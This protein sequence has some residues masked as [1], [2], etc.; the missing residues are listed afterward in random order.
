MTSHLDK[1]ASAHNTASPRQAVKV[2]L[3]FLRFSVRTFPKKITAFV[4]IRILEFGTQIIIAAILATMIQVK[5]SDDIGVSNTVLTDTLEQFGLTA[6]AQGEMIFGII[7]L[8]AL[9][10]VN[11]VMTY[12]SKRILTR[13]SIETETILSADIIASSADINYAGY[14]ALSGRF[15]Q[16]DRREIMRMTAQNTRLVGIV[17][18]NLIDALFAGLQLIV[19]FI[20]LIVLGNNIAPLLILGTFIVGVIGV[21][22]LFRA[23]INHSVNFPASA[24]PASASRSNLLTQ[25]FSGNFKGR[26][27]E[28]EA[29]YFRDQKISYSMKQYEGRFKII[30]QGNLI[31]N[32]ITGLALIVLMYYLFLYETMINPVTLVAVLLVGNILFRS[33]QQLFGFFVIIGRLYDQVRKIW[34]FRNAPRHENQ[35]NIVQAITPSGAQNLG[36]FP[37]L[38][39]SDDE[40]RVYEIKPGS[41]LAMCSQDPMEPFSL[42]QLLDRID[43][44]DSPAAFSTNIIVGGKAFLGG[45]LSQCEPADISA[46]DERLAAVLKAYRKKPKEAELESARLINSYAALASGIVLIDFKH[47]NLLPNELLKRLLD[48][49]IKGALV[50][51]GRSPLLGLRGLDDIITACILVG[52]KIKVLSTKEALAMKGEALRAILVQKIAA[53]LAD[54]DDSELE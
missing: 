41:A 27:E 17:N 3:Y 36:L 29:R 23:G 5:M 21:I 54:I 30:D 16:F 42:F 2:L 9:L 12:V 50:F 37:K 25:A 47:I 34:V 38:I 14:K 49:P 1:A 4:G 35:N 46:A 18:R 52:S 40:K 7:L 31:N 11:I 15:E 19:V 28:L 10:A 39:D 26:K 6:F 48:M 22:W 32:A 13:I 43:A 53:P 20:A 24:V 45:F 33:L 44:G 51:Y 8:A